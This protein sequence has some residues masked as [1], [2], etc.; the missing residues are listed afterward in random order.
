V[1]SGDGDIGADEVWIAWPGVNDIGIGT[2]VTLDMM[3]DFGVSDELAKHKVGSEWVLETYYGCSF[4]VYPGNQRKSEQETSQKSFFMA[5]R[6]VLHFKPRVAFFINGAPRRAAN[7]NPTPEQKALAVLES[8]YKVATVKINSIKFGGTIDEPAIFNICLK[9]SDMRKCFLKVPDAILDSYIIKKMPTA[10]PITDWRVLLDQARAPVKSDRYMKPD[11]DAKSVKSMSSEAPDECICSLGKACALHP[12]SCGVCVMGSNLK[13]C[14]WRRNF[15]TFAQTAAYRKLKSR[16]L[17]K[18]RVI[19]NDMKLK[20]VPTYTE[21]AHK[22]R[23]KLADLQNPRD[24]AL[25]NILSEAH[26]LFKPF[27]VV[28]IRTTPGKSQISKHGTIP[29]VRFGRLFVPMAGTFLTL[30]QLYILVGYPLT[31][32]RLE[33]LNALHAKEDIAFTASSFCVPTLAKIMQVALS[34]LI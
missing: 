19:K 22:R 3:T 25:L 32:E 20:S 11:K 1:P 6:T 30:K 28:A 12:C 34:M 2:E 29:S 4:P 15:R 26:N 33:K 24:R 14:L 23:D 8:A 17:K 16:F 10:P 18:W 9:R 31:K 21:L 5:V 13:K 27:I 7:G